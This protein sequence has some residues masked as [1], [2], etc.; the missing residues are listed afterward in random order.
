[1]K[2]LWFFCQHT[3][4]ASWKCKS[5]TVKWCFCLFQFH[6][7]TKSIDY[8]LFFDS[9]T[10]L[11]L[12]AMFFGWDPNDLGWRWFSHQHDTRAK[13]FAHGLNWI[14]IW[15]LFCGFG[16][17]LF[18][19]FFLSFSNKLICKNFEFHLQCSCIFVKTSNPSFWFMWCLFLSK[20]VFLTEKWLRWATKG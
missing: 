17:V 1:M 12:S 3:A 7:L 15:T 11:G 10:F 16:M 19:P 4:S 8:I 6:T 9:F 5:K 18:E 13:I 2:G 14:R 20:N